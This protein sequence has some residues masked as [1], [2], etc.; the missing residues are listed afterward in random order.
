MSLAGGQH[1]LEKLCLGS[2]SFS[3]I[4][5]IFLFWQFYG[6]LTF[7]VTSVSV[8]QKSLF[9]HEQHLSGFF[10]KNVFVSSLLMD[11]LPVSVWMM[12]W[13]KWERDSPSDIGIQIILDR[14]NSCSSI[15]MLCHQF[16]SWM[17]RTIKPSCV[18]HIIIYNSAQ[19]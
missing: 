16:N 14:E 5:L 2:N 17:R 13:Q 9:P 6:E 10:F 15:L 3:W 7:S 4:H 11:S 18:C 19:E 8:M 12:P 1:I